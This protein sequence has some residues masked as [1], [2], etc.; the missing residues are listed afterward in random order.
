MDES[1]GGL[2]EGFVPF[3]ENMGFAEL[4]GP[5]FVHPERRS[6][7]FRVE[8]R[9]CNPIGICHGGMM[10]TVMDMAI[11]MAIHAAG[12]ADGFPPSIN[13][14]YDFLA[15]ARAGEWLESR[16]DFVHTTRRTGFANGYLMGEQGPLLRASGICKIPGSSNPVFGGTDW[17]RGREP[18]ESGT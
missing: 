14:A 9:H 18:D 7:G 16:V 4:V 6:I 17:R 2:P 8:A 12:G 3:P 15:P 13:L 10:M 11:G 1:A 5:L